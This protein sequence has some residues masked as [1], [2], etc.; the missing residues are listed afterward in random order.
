MTLLS[1]KGGV[2]PPEKKLTKN[3]EIKTA[4]LPQKVVVFMLQHA[5]A[6]AKPIVQVGQQVKTGQVIGEPQGT[7][8][9]YVHSPVTG[10]V[11]S[12]SKINSPV[13]G[14][15]VEAI[16]IERTSD[17][18]WELLPAVDYERASREELLDIVKKA[19][20]VGLGGAM[21]PTHVKLAPP[22]PVDTLII[23]GAE[24][25]PYLTIDHRV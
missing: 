22:K 19:G 16:T 2:H 11:T 12:V 18:D 25:E 20:I 15:A 7:I 21:F 23:N 8:S 24:C 4:P 13:H 10:T 17:D 6:P 5:G 1:F 14:M 9:A 3:A